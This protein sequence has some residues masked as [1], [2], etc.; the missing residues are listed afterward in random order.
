[1]KRILAALLS[2][3]LVAAPAIAQNAERVPLPSVP[4]PPPDMAP[5]DDAIEPEV[6]IKKRDEVTVEE[7]RIHGRLY[8]VKVT[9]KVGP[10]FYLIDDRGDGNFTRRDSLDS[11]VRPPM[12]LIGTF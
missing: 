5:F 2:L 9:P 4:P 10:P 1:M 6:T 11:G 8:M 12:W 7:Y 3:A